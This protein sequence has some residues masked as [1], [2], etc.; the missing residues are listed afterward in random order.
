MRLLYIFLLMLFLICISLFVYKLPIAYKM[1]GL[2]QVEH[3]YRDDFD[4]YKQYRETKD[5]IQNTVAV[6]YKVSLWYSFI[7]FV[8]SLLIWIL[9]PF[10][11]W[12]L[13]QIMTVLSGL[14]FLI[15]F[16]IDNTHFIPTGPIR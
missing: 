10:K 13:I 5:N 15:L 16:I 7:F 3:L 11:M 6:V 12:Y 14:I 1:E 8:I 9:R 2:D 4:S